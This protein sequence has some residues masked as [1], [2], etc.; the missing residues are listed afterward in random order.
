MKAQ[1]Y[2]HSEECRSRVYEA[3]RKMQDPKFMAAEAADAD[4]T[5]SRLN[6]EPKPTPP[7]DPEGPAPAT[8]DLFPVY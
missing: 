2:N 3:L 6:N 5:Q 1:K 4:R 7:Q 8:D